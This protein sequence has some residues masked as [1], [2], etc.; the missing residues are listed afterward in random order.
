MP[1]L[2]GDK[3]PCAPDPSRLHPVSLFI[4]I[5]YNIFYNKCKCKLCLP[6]FCEGSSQTLKPEE[7]GVKTP[8]S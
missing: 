8:R 7:G 2:H 1:Q 5:F 4:C 3:C 6:D